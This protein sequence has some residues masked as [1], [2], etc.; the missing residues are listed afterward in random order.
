[1]P[2]VVGREIGVD[3]LGQPPARHEGVRPQVGPSVAELELKGDGGQVA[4]V[5]R[6]MPAQQRSPLKSSS[7]RGERARL[8]SSGEMKVSSVFFTQMFMHLVRKSRSSPPPM[9]WAWACLG[10]YLL[11][12][13]LGGGEDGVRLDPVRLVEGIVPLVQAEDVA[14]HVLF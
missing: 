13:A 6:S 7:V 3:V 1:M 5:D 8:R 14:E 10:A 4:A 12:P 9:A 11:H 2:Q